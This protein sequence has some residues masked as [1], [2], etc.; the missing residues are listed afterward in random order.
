MR[1]SDPDIDKA[2]L[3]ERLAR[4]SLRTNSGNFATLAAI[5]RAVGG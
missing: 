2:I 1:D 3:I 5:R 4:Y